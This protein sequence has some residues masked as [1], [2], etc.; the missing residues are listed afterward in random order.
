MAF[1]FGLYLF[2][3]RGL[4]LFSH[5]GVNTRSKGQG[6]RILAQAESAKGLSIS[7]NATPR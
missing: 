1:S 4:F 6:T 5:C 3:N 2:A 7:C